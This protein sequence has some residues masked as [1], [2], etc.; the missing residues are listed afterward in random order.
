MA[1]REEFLFQNHQ[2][3]TYLKHLLEKITK[4][5]GFMI[6]TINSHLPI[7]SHGVKTFEFICI[8]FTSDTLPR[9]Q[10]ICR[11]LPWVPY[12]TSTVLLQGEFKKFNSSRFPLLVE[13]TNKKPQFISFLCVDRTRALPKS[14]PVT[15]NYPLTY[16]HA[17]SSVLMCGHR[18]IIANKRRWMDFLIK[19]LRRFSMSYISKMYSSIHSS[20]PDKSRLLTD[21]D[22][23]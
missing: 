4:A 9:N 13:T 12:P 6:G 16:T 21:R 7:Q 14:Q 15:L 11:P 19:V 18:Y 5:G 22:R 20:M 2:K 17:Q 23:Y 10:I 1:D 8:Y 3:Y